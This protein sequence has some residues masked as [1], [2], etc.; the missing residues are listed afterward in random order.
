MGD[1]VIRDLTTYE[2]CVQV[3]E[4]QLACFG[5]S[6]HE[7]IHPPMLLIAGQSGG[8]V[9]GAFDGDKMVGYLFGFLGLHENRGP[10]KLC[11]QTM[12]VLPEYRGRGIA[13]QLKWAQR[14]RALKLG[15][16]LITWTYDPLE[17]PNAHLN[18]HKLGGIARAYERNVYGERLNALTEG[19]P[20]DRLLV[21]WWIGQISNIKSQMPS[22]GGAVVTSVEG[23]GPAQRLVDYEL[24]SD[25]EVVRVETPMS[26]QAIRREN[27]A[28]AV[29]W[30]LKTRE[31]FE[32]YFERGYI[33]VD[34]ASEGHGDARRNL[35]VL[36]RPPAGWLAALTG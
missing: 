5:F 14:E 36:W 8:V 26:V 16:R 33:A 7:G 10:L 22:T 28:R 19:M 17:G 25:D 2:E 30:R 3:R 23:S 9:L 31:I 13:E 4:L 15:L 12:A 34:F 21:E 6:S 18:L 11:S 32:T 20:T 27:M 35:Y 24:D 1:I 29:D